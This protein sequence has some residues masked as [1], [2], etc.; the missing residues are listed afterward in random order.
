M[1]SDFWKQLKKPIMVTAPMSGV[2][3]DAFR[4]MFLRYG[5]P[6]VFWTEFVSVEGLFSKGREVCLKVLDFL[7]EEKPI[8]A[9]VFGSEPSALRWLL[10]I[11][12]GLVLM[13]ST[14]TWVVQIEP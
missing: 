6:D 10:K 3:D 13:V 5:R 14:S 12:K 7:P 9:Q 2:T 11:L 1:P 4:Q 8:I